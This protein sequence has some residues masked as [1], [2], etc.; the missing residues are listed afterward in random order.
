MKKD[1]NKGI[2][3]KKRSIWQSE[4]RFFQF[5]LWWL[6]FI[7]CLFTFTWYLGISVVGDLIKNG[8]VN[9]LSHQSVVDDATFVCKYYLMLMGGTYG[10]LAFLM[11]FLSG[12]RNTLNGVVD[13]VAKLIPIGDYDNLVSDYYEENDDESYKPFNNDSLITSTKYIGYPGNIYS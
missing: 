6:A 1:I 2:V 10:V 8:S 12:L 4:V 3:M 7:P 11:L 13:Y 5:S 9:W